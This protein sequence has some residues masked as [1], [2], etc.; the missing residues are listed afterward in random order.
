MR[1]KSIVLM[2]SAVLILATVIGGTIA[3][4]IDRTGPVVNTFT[5]GNIDIEL[6]ETKTNFKMVPGT[7]IE[8]DPVVTV[9]AKSE[10]CWLF[11]KVEKSDNLDSFI[12][13]DIAN[14]WHQLE[15]YSG[16]YYRNV[17]TSTSNQDFYVLEG[18]TVT[19]KNTVTKQ[20]LGDLTENNLPEL[21]FTAYAIQQAGFEERPADAWT[22][23]NNP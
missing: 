9:E 4:L 15:G 18:N 20:M 23:I 8:K 5:V 11:V 17:S 14:G 7:A 21:T 2:A 19:V 10:A 3:W 13:Y 1:K 22:A 6:A 12:E 16:I